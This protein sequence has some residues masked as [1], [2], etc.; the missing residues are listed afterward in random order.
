M[1]SLLL[2]I[3]LFLVT[4]NVTEQFK[5]VM[6]VWDFVLKGRGLWQ[7]FEFSSEPKMYFTLLLQIETKVQH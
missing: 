7:M 4:A 2:C 5:V 1:S 6:V 3:V